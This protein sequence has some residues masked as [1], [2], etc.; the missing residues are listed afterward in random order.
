MGVGV[1]AV[2]YEVA[3]FLDAVANRLRKHK[4]RASDRWWGECGTGT[5]G[6]WAAT[7]R[8]LVAE[9]LTALVGRVEVRLDGHADAAAHDTI[10]VTPAK[11]RLHATHAL[12]LR[13]HR[14]VSVLSSKETVLPTSAALRWPEAPTRIPPETQGPT[15]RVQ[16]D[17]LAAYRHALQE[18]HVEVELVPLDRGPLDLDEGQ[19]DVGL[20]LLGRLRTAQTQECERRCNSAMRS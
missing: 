3:G 9:V 18:P 20:P 17:E 1:F 8:Q 12:I 13:T 5:L 10:A 7:H 14:K 15:P 4:R 11:R 19:R 6:T 16:F 2:A